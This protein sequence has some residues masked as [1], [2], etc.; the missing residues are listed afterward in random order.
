VVSIPSPTGSATLNF[1][2]PNIPALL[3]Q[4]LYTQALF[5]HRLTPLEARFSNVVSDR[6]VR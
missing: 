2:L 4:T 3:G 5:V 6:L 1:P